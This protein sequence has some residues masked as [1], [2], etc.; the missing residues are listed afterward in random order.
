MST[1]HE[2]VLCVTHFDWVASISVCYVLL[3][4]DVGDRFPCFGKAHGWVSA[5]ECD[6][7]HVSKYVK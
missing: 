6:F 2:K 4:Q 5:K 3:G 1:F 7:L